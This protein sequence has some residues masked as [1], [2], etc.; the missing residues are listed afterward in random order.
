MRLSPARLGSENLLKNGYSATLGSGGNGDT[1][2]P[3]LMIVLSFG[4]IV[5]LSAE[6]DGI[7]RVFRSY[8]LH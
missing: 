5:L 6:T 8:P 1:E 4:A 7:R 3:Y 2:T